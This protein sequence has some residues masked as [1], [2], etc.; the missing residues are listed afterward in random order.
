M[1]MSRK[2]I[3]GQLKPVSS[4]IITNQYIGH[5]LKVSYIQSIGGNSVYSKDRVDV[6]E[7]GAFRLFLPKQELLT[8]ESV[9]IE[10]FAPN[11][12][13]LSKQIKSVRSLYPADVPENVEDKTTP[14]IISVDPQINEF[15]IEPVYND[16]LKISGKLVDVSGENKISNV[17]VIIFATVNSA[18][19]DNYQGIF[20]A[21]TNKDGYFFGRI[22][23]R[24]YEE[25]YAT[26]AGLDSVKIPIKLE[27]DKIPAELLLVWDLSSYEPL[28]FK[29]EDVPKLPDANE[30]VMN[31]VFSQDIGGKC[32]DFTTP[33]RTLEE[34]SFGVCQVSCRI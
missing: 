9:S 7:D 31:S 5:F 16:F 17:E 24:K 19:S 3:N 25:A 21:Q 26:I 27:K 29:K 8:E 22:K 4:I 23:N 33:N 18:E 32:V 34:F 13:L 12:S 11:G 10:V 2:S 14:F 28:G 20:S 30:L 1:K 15:V 6:E